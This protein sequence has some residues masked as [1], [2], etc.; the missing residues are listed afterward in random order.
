[1][2]YLA[3][4]LMMVYAYVAAYKESV[5]VR[6][7]RDYVPIPNP[8]NEPFHFYGITMAAPMCAALFVS[9]IVQPSIAAFV[10]TPFVSISIYWA[11]FSWKLH[12]EIWDRW[13]YV[14]TTAKFDIWLRKK[15][16]TKVEQKVVSIQVSL[17][18]LLNLL[19][20]LFK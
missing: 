9:Q 2:F 12:D 20:L 7:M 17:F 19:Y 16:G 1:M 8:Y 15:L 14:G 18:V 4:I 13:N 3:Q 10:L 5:A 11:V 6:M